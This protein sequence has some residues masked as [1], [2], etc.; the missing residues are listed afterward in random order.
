MGKKPLRFP[1][2]KTKKWKKTRKKI[3]NKSFFF[4]ISKNLKKPKKIFKNFWKFWKKFEELTK[5]V[6]KNWKNG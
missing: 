4:L 6:K 2:E 5:N 1:E 3:K